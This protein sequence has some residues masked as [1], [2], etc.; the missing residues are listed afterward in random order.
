MKA[1]SVVAIMIGLVIGRG[2][3][4]LWASGPAGCYALLEKVVLEP[5]DMAP[6]RIQVWG[7]F[8]ISDGKPALGYLEPQRGYLYFVLPPA[9]NQQISSGRRVPS[10]PIAL[11]EWADLKTIAGT[12]QVVALG[13]RMSSLT[14]YW[15]TRVRTSN[16]KPASPEVY[17]V[18]NGITRMSPFTEPAQ[19]LIAKLREAVR[20]T[21]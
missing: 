7:V 1:K 21:K 19:Q 18:Y 11:A 5:N 16:E 4:T 20:K 6:E 8:A 2:A 17:P 12:G 14:S 15:T 10:R 13:E 3:V 9:E